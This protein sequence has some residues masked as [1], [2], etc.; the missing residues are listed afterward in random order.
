MYL[1]HKLELDPTELDIAILESQSKIANNLYNRLL[2]MTRK[3]MD[4][5]KENQTHLEFNP[6]SSY[7]LRNQV[8]QIKQEHQFYKTLYSSVAKNVALRLGESIHNWLDYLKHKDKYPNKVGFPH[9]RSLKEKGFF[10]L[11]YEDK[12]VGYKIIDN[13]LSLSFGRDEDKKRIKALIQFKRKF[14]IDLN[15]IRTLEI[16]KD[17]ETFF[18]CFAC[19]VPDLEKKEIKK[20]I[21]FDPNHKNL[22]VGYSSDQETLEI[23]N[24]YF[25]K[26]FDKRIDELKSKRDKCKKLSRRWR[27]LNKILLDLYRVKREQIQVALRTISNYLCKN[28]DLIAIGDY[29]PSKQKYKN[30]NRAMINQTHIGEFRLILEHICERSGKTYFKYDEYN[31]TKTC[32]NCGHIG[33]KLDPTIREWTCDECGEFHLRDENSAQNGYVITTK[34]YKLPCSGHRD[35]LSRCICWFNGNAII[36]Q[37]IKGIKENDTSNLIKSIA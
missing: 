37:E 26:E 3:E 31:T 21:A 35:I 23:K 22:A 5:Y 13:K 25:I 33:K 6:L 30:M 20:V 18:A 27:Y 11:L 7:D 19:E 24:L 36:R 8:P 34:E 9:F 32:N 14:N 4:Y 17:R 16:V 29:V 10:S 28:Y 2:E 1:C 15:S 12:F